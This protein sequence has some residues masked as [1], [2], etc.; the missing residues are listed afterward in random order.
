MSLKDIKQAVRIKNS[1]PHPIPKLEASGGITLRNV[2]QVAST[3][4]DMISIGDLTHSVDS[5]DIS[6]EIV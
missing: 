6:L 1:L 5:V 3:G 4:I 2:K